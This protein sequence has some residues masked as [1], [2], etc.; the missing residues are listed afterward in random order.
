M[1][2]LVAPSVLAADFTQLARDIEMVNRSEADMFHVDVMDGRFVPNISFGM[3]IIEAIKKL[4]TKPLDVHLMIVEPEKYI[5]AFRKSGADI[6][7]VHVEACPHLHR[8]LEQIRAT[9]AK[10][11][12][13]INPHTPV[14]MLEDILSEADLFCLMSVNPG[15]GG[16]KFI[17]QTLNKIKKLRAMLDE[18]NLD[19]HIEIDGGVGLQNAEVILQ[20]GADVLVAGSSVFA[21]ANPT[22][23]ISDMKA[24]SI[25]KFDN[26]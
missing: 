5:D 3:M 15:F 6:I 1:K 9:G 22:K 2:H 7:T 21:A 4:A 8:T 12:V 25:S 26:F 11:G 14:S 19:A 20:A 16:Q 10:A 18:R 23:A 24:L 13:A 17:Y